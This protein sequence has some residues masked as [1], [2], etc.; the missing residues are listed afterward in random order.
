M[1]KAF[2]SGLEMAS[3]YFNGGAAG[4]PRPQP[5]TLVTWPGGTAL[6][7][8]H[9]WQVGEVLHSYTWEDGSPVAVDEF[10]EAII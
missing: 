2:S 9:G 1:Q 8:H 7:L 5:G 10:F 3:Y 4:G 6:V